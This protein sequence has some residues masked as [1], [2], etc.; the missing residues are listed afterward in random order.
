MKT[1]WIAVLLALSLAAAKAQTTSS[2]A[3]VVID[4]SGAVIPDAEIVLANSETN[5][6][7][8][9]KTDSQGRYSFS[10]TQPGI[11]QVSARATG[12]SEVVIRDVRLRVNTP[13]A[14]T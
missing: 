7:R 2:L 10:Q 6:R 5:A 11:Y 8:T 12:F 1:Y 9:T 3:G 4:P 14:V 13:S